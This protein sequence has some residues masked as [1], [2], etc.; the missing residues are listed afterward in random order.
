LRPTDRA[1]RKFLWSG[2]FHDGEITDINYNSHGDKVTLKLNRSLYDTNIYRDK[3]KYTGTSAEHLAID[4][5]IAKGKFA[6]L[7]TFSKT[8]YFHQENSCSSYEYLYGRF[9]DTALLRRLE[10]EHKTK[11]YHFRIEITHGYIDLIF[12]K[13]TI[14][15][16]AGRVNYSTDGYY[17]EP[18]EITCSKDEINQIHRKIEN[19]GYDDDFDLYDDLEKLY[20]MQDE[21]ILKYLRICITF[22]KDYEDSRVYATYLLGKFGDKSD[23]PK[24][25]EIY[26]ECN[27]LLQKIHI[28]DAIELLK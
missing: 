23:L 1:I 11:L 12:K 3:M 9:K 17:L 25:K 28:M 18:R 13:F 10:K 8:L 16:I 26:F 6:Y 4:E 27:D 22:P 19:S 14:K 2:Y 15:K 20:E 7:L 21:S 5:L 24:M